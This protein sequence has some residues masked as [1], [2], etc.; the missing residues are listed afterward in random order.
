LPPPGTAAKAQVAPSN[1]V[2]SR[3]PLPPLADAPWRVEAPKPSE[4][5]S[6]VEGAPALLLRGARLLLGNGQAIADGHVLLVK[7]RIAAVGEGPGALP[8]E[9]RVIELGGKTVTPGLIDTHSHMGV[10]PMPAAQAHD[11]GNEMTAATTSGVRTLDAIWPFDPAFQR[12]VEGGTT[13]VQ[14]LPGS[15]NLIG[16]RATTLKLKPAR[17]AR[18][19]VFPGAP[20]GL[21]MACGENPKRVHGRG[22]RVAP[23]TRMGNL[24]G[25]RAA[26]LK[27]RRLIDEWAQWASSELGRRAAWETKSLETLRK[28]EALVAKREAC[29]AKPNP[30]RCLS[31]LDAANGGILPEVE[32]FEAKLPPA[33]D[34]DSEALAA[35]LEGLSPVHV[36]C[37]RSDDMGAMLAL[38]DEVRFKVTSFHHALEAYKIKDEL[39]RRKV[40]VSTWADWFGFKLEANDGIPENLALIHAAG[41]DAIVHTDSPEGVRRM[42]QEAA[43]GLWSGRHAGYPI[44][45]ADAIRWVTQNP[46][47]ALGIERWVGTLEV[48]KDADVVVWSG[49]PFSVY[50]RAELVLVDGIVRHDAAQPAKPWSDFEVEP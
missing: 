32:A 28:R 18:E 45:E 33:R 5:P 21:K 17:T 37:Y 6:A 50:T 49:N 23:G 48:G 42:N 15:A 30:D 27:A 38:A 46:A 35:V 26:F 25:Q 36:H 1:A 44:E 22:R 13:T 10:F 40:S 2:A 31:P 19:L 41:A 11:D 24:A 14:V 39:A 9:A 43:K 20:F 16:G 8:A 34:P 7:G 3:P 12:A 4:H 47:R 29:L